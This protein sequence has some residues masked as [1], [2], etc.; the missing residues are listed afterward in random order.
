MS[1]GKLPTVVCKRPRCPHCRGIRL[2]TGRTIRV[3][4]ESVT[5]W[6]RCEGCKK[7]FWLAL[8]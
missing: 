2:R 6:A 8:E 4:D 3:D 7:T 5:R 1:R